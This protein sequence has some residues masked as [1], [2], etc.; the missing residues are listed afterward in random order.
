MIMLKLTCGV[1]RENTIN[2]Y[3]KG[4][5]IVAWKVEEDRDDSNMI[6]IVRLVK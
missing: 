1:T 3:I 6:F 2:K 5:I 4:S